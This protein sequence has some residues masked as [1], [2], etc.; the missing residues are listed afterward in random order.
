M[1]IKGSGTHRKQ[2]RTL[3]TEEFQRLPTELREPA[4]LMVLLAG[5]LGLRVSE[6]LALKWEDIDEADATIAIQ[7]SFTH[8]HLDSTKTRVSANVRTSE[9]CRASAGLS[10][11]SPG[12][13]RGRTVG[14]TFDSI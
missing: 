10:G 4:N 7:R 13:A 6:I 5:C 11:C 9:G 3:T 12:H 1:R 14:S 2:I 8:G